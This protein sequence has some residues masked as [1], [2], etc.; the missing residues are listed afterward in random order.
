MRKREIGLTSLMTVPVLAGAGFIGSHA[1]AE[2][3]RRRSAVR[4]F[5]GERENLAAAGIEPDPVERDVRTDERISA[6]P[7]L[8]RTLTGHTVVRP[9]PLRRP[10]SRVRTPP[11]RL[12]SWGR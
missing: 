10:S 5:A 6:S 1:T 3:R 12:T 9:C 2:L 8:R 11:T 4:V 7:Q